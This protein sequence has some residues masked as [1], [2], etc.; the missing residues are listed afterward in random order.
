MENAKITSQELEQ[1]G[2]TSA[3]K[4]LNSIKEFN[5]KTSIAYEHFRYV[6]KEQFDRFNK[7]LREKTESK[8][9]EDYKQYDRLQFIQL[10]QYTE[11]PPINVLEKLK[12]AKVRD[13]FDY[14]EVAKIESHVER[15]DPILFGCINN[16]PDKFFVSQWDNDVSIEDILHELEG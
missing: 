1:L 9:K 4:K 7:E 16:C 12:E 5:R 6:T 10:Q 13:C 3:A 15:P 14:F 11:I 2:L 8:T